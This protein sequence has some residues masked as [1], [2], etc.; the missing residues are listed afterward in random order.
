MACNN[1]YIVQDCCDS[2]N[3]FRVGDI[4]MTGLTNGD[5]FYTECSGLTTGST[6]FTF[7][8][9]VV[10]NSSAPILAN[11]A[12]TFSALTSYTACTDCQ[13]AISGTPCPTPTP[14]VTP[15]TT[16]TSG[17]IYLTGQ[18]SLPA[19]L[20]VG[21]IVTDSSGNCWEII[22][23]TGTTPN[24]TWGNQIF[25]VGGCASCL[26]VNPCP[27]LTPTV[28]PT[29]TPTNTV[30]PTVTPT[31]LGC[32]A[33][34]IQ[35]NTGISG[36]TFT[37][38]DCSGATQ[39]VTITSGNSNTVCSL[40]VPTTSCG[41]SAYTISN[42]GN[43]CQTY[44]I[45]VVPSVNC[46]FTYV[47][48]S[49]VTQ[50]VTVTGGT[51]TTVCSLTVPTTPC[52]PLSYT[53]INQ[54]FCCLTYNINVNSNVTGCTFSYINCSGSSQ[55]ITITSG[56]SLSL[57]S[58]ITPT[59]S[60]PTSAYTMTQSGSCCSYYNLSVVDTSCT[61]S[62]VD[63]SGNSQ[64]VVVTSATSTSIC[65]QVIPTTSCN[66]T[67]YTIT[68]AATCNDCVTYTITNNNSVPYTFS[69]IDC[70]GVTQTITVPANGGVVVICTLTIPTAPKGVA[71]VA[72]G[73]CC[74]TYNINVGSGVSG[75]T[76]TY[77]DCSG[78]TQTVTITSGNSTTLCA[79]TVP[80]TSCGASAYT[81]TTLGTCCTTYN[82][83]VGS[84]VSGCTFTYTDCS[85]STQ[86]VTITSGNSNTICA[87]SVPT[88]SCGASAYT[89]TNLG[90]CNPSTCYYISVQAGATYECYIDYDDPISGFTTIV[91]PSATTVNVCSTS[92]PVVSAISAVCSP[93]DIVIIAGSACTYNV[94][95][96]SWNC[97]SV[98]CKCW[99]IY[100]EAPTNCT[101]PYVDCDGIIQFYPL[102]GG[103]TGNTV[104]SPYT[105]DL[106]NCGVTYTATTSGD[107]A[108]A[109]SGVYE[110]V[111]CT[112]EC[113]TLGYDELS[114]TIQ[115][116]DLTA[117][118]STVI[119]TS[120][121][122]DDIAS[123]SS[124]IWGFAGTNIYEYPW[125]SCPLSFSA[126]SRTITITGF[127][128][129][130]L[131]S[132]SIGVNNN[133]LIC[134]DGGSNNIYELDITTTTAIQ[135]L[136][137]SAPVGRN[138]VNDISYSATD[139][140]L[141][142][143]SGVSGYYITQFDYNSAIQE[144]D[145]LWSAG[146]IPYSFISDSSNLYVVDNSG[147]I[148]Q[149]QTTTPYTQTFVQTPSSPFK[150]TAQYSRICFLNNL[151]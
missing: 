132:T 64:S 75:C 53:I 10:V 84:G 11:A 97:P 104:C 61:F 103:T 65:S 28:T 87:L 20:T 57:C 36:C 137:L 121:I 27:T 74:Q 147:D 77:T 79:I 71:I 21:M 144:V 141:T 76:F 4:C 96:S 95:G 123:T 92:L 138:F 33:Y 135:T 66:P 2:S 85:G 81:I 128:G 101:I 13:T 114:G 105:P 47:D 83:Q 130:V 45:S 26:T 6:S 17:L 136:I 3:S 98:Q 22:A 109:I 15:T 126:A 149:I 117:N 9:C 111:P 18:M 41:A 7:S 124:Y 39:T 5:I 72:G 32:L 8:G 88:T 34:N 120:L 142:I 107:C 86:T 129:S 148:Y 145:V 70:S 139:K 112:T 91:I 23:T 73:N 12:D 115:Y 82:I 140:L 48:C 58:I 59:T 19:T 44:N 100:I 119:I 116:Y 46:T 38:I 94:S 49:G 143:T 151:T 24:L 127:T 69:Y 51:S 80:T 43:C 52:S 106:T 150:Y 122:V 1:Q 31:S 89:I 131:G 67:G 99:D 63:C 68:S 102:S 35:V 29:N 55:T 56:L 42:I 54:G 50:T 25:P 90:N 125:D 40:T 93:S 37:Y 78:N 60:C 108:I 134:S 146:T 16:N 62:Y 30:T 113:L 118:T 110:C 14:T 133:Q